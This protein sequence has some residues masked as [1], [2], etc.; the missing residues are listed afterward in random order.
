MEYSGEQNQ[1][2]FSF[3]KELFDKISDIHKDIS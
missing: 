3:R 2:F 1:R